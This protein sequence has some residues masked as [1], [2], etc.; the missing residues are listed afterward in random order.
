MKPNNLIALLIAVILIIIGVALGVTNYQSQNSAQEATEAKEVDDVF[1]TI[2]KPADSNT[3]KA[4]T[5]NQ[6]ALIHDDIGAPAFK[7]REKSELEL[8]RGSIDW[9]DAP[10]PAPELVKTDDYD[11]YINVSKEYLMYVFDK[12]GYTGEKID[13]GETTAIPPLLVVSISKGWS[14]GETVQ[15]KKSIFYRVILSLVL[16]E[17]E[18]VLRE[19]D[20]LLSILEARE[21]DTISS[22]QLKALN[23]LAYSYRAVKEESDEPLTEAQIQDLLSRVDI[24]PA[25]LALAQAAHESGYASSRF[26]HSANA[27]FGQWDWSANAVKPQQQRKGMGNYGIKSFDQPVDSVRA[28]IWNLNTHR[29][30]AGFRKERARQRGDELGLIVFD[31]HK[32]AGT[33]T[34]YSERGEEYTKELQDTISHNRLGRAD[35]LRLMKGDPIYFN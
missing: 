13:S 30:Y 23:R 19:R 35:N 28:Y 18:A 12:L 15:F 10:S 17:N 6:V 24:V 20:K 33:L 9:S 14:D 3:N 29:A 7:T 8:I 25:S 31:G 32:L 11:V 22:T 26:A 2:T 27:L 5:L 21:D 34:S 4:D 16:F 1:T